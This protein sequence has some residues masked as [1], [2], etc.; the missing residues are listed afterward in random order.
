MSLLERTKS[1][2]PNTAPIKRLRLVRKS[3]K[4]SKDNAPRL[5]THM[6][7]QLS[8]VSMNL[9]PVQ[10]YPPGNEILIA[11]QL[12]L[13][14][15]SSWK[16]SKYYS[17]SI[18]VTT[19][20]KA[21]VPITV[22]VSKHSDGENEWFQ[23]RTEFSGFSPEAYEEI[24]YKLIRYFIGSVANVGASHCEYEQYY[25]LELE[26]MNIERV[27]QEGDNRAVF[28]VTRYC[29]LP[30]PLRDRVFHQLVYIFHHE[31]DLYIVQVP[32]D[33][34]GQK[35]SA[36]LGRYVLVD[37]IAV[38]NRSKSIVWQLLVACQPGGLVAEKML[39]KLP[40]MLAKDVPAF[41]KWAAQQD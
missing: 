17:Y 13:A 16:V 7:Q 36:A 41:F 10:E 1:I 32:L 8:L 30:F 24:K 27:P 4:P 5:P 20:P 35:F 37:R 23:R 15:S 31:N 39:R 22:E 28:K 18:P 29:N 25:L 6:L 33:A 38:D 2:L 34:T 19:G 12:I 9:N 3:A 14:S 26:I 40:G 11:A 21:E